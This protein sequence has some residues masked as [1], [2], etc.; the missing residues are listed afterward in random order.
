MKIF[1]ISW[2]GKT[3]ELSVIVQSQRLWHKTREVTSFSSAGGEGLVLCVLFNSD[4]E[5]AIRSKLP[6]LVKDILIHRANKLLLVM[7]LHHI[8]LSLKYA[9]LALFISRC[10]S[11]YWL[12]LFRL[13]EFINVSLF[14]ALLFLN[15]KWPYIGITSILFLLPD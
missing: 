2:R 8:T 13:W 12:L 3:S 7:N 15:L 5:N 4:L 6:F 9:Y 1:Q 11:T 14:F 10:N